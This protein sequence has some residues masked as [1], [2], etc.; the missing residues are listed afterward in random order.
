MTIC[1]TGSS[2]F[3]GTHLATALPEAHLFDYPAHDLRDLAD[4]EAFINDNQPEV[5]FHLAA[6]SVVTNDDDIQTLDTNISGT[7]NLMHACRKDKNLRSFVH[8]STDKVYGAGSV[9]RKSP[10]N[11]VGHPYNASKLCGDVIAQMYGNHY[12]IPVRII[13]SGNIYGPG[14][15]HYDRIVPGTIKATLEGKPMQ[16]RSNGWMMRDYI[17]IADIIKG[18]IRVADEPEGIYNLGAKEEATVLYIVHTITWLME[19]DDL[20]PVILDSQR[21][22]L[23]YQHV[24]DCPKW[25]HP[26]VDLDDGLERTIRWY[27]NLFRA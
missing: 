20:E 3:I 5:V 12:G 23:D 21:N 26:A 13:R 6:Q 27:K 9:T 2:G 19:R 18:I 11:G 14:D 10:L 7:Y 1:I 22:E 4:A 17:Y 24:T 16:L 15:T 25:W 8:I